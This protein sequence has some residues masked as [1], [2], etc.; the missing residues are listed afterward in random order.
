MAWYFPRSRG[1]KRF[2]GGDEVE[3]RVREA[4]VSWCAVNYLQGILRLMGR[5]SGGVGRGGLKCNTGKWEP[6]G[7]YEG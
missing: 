4:R 2:L 5:S 1:C 3:F 7:L 6:F